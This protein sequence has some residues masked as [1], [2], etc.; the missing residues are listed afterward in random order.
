MAGININLCV[1]VGMGSMLTLVQEP[2]EMNN[3]KNRE[4]G[5][6]LMNIDVSSA[7]SDVVIQRYISEC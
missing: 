5:S 3:F 4:F 1:V 2:M 6:C 7:S